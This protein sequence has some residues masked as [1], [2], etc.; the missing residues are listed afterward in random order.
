MTSQDTSTEIS[1]ETRVAQ[2]VGENVRRSRT[3][4]SGMI[5]TVVEMTFDH[6][7]P[8][9]AKLGSAESGFPLEAA[10]I[11]HLRSAS[12]VPVPRVIHVE[13][14]LIIMESVPGDHIGPAGEYHCATLLASLHGVPQPAS[15]FGGQTLNG[16]VVL[17]SPWTSSWIEFFREHRLQFA[18]ELAAAHY[19]LPTTLRH[20]LD[21]IVERLEHLI[22]EPDQVSLMHGDLWPANVLAIDDRVT[23]FLDPSVCYG[24]AELELAYIDV[25]DS[26]GCAFWNRYAELRPINPD[27][28]RLRRHVYALYPLLMHV[29]YFGDRFMPN[30]TETVSAIEKDL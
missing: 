21:R 25:F 4:A 9:V 1:T 13:N 24:D 2:I 5:N 7:P 19:A 3:L 16:R 17:E 28:Y 23:A 12:V 29:Y 18:I 6:L 15:G 10:M 14:D 27:F 22:R 20:T 11:N 26:M 30:L 8:V